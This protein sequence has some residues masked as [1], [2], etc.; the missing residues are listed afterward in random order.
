MDRYGRALKRPATENMQSWRTTG[1]RGRWKLHAVRREVGEL[2]LQ[3]V[4]N[5]PFEPRPKSGPVSLGEQPAWLKIDRLRGR[6]S[7]RHGLR[8][9]AGSSTP[10]LRE[11]Q[12]L[13]WLRSHGFEALEPLAAGA[14]LRAGLPTLQFLFT[15]RISNAATLL[16]HLEG[17]Q[18]RPER[19]KL[20]EDL[21][22]DLARLHSLGF[23]HH[24]LFLRNLLVRASAD[25]PR[26]VFIDTWRG[27]PA[28]QWRG[29]DYDL[30]CLLLEGADL[31]EERELRIFLDSYLRTQA[32]MKAAAR[33]RFL[34]RV[35]R[36]RLRLLRRLEQ[37]PGRR[38][39]RPLPS[40]TWDPRTLDLEVTRVS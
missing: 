35:H 25:R 8:T 33:A 11:F 40:V 24:D 12:N 13:L 29:P 27:G 9:L 36:Q 28:P 18:D 14:L 6:A 31:L 22:R 37:Q 39:G 4:E 3:L 20:I 7:L 38:R 26:L 34:S 2:A 21:G 32:P 19:A 16:E 1:P 30:A 5:Q 15:S 23:I 17:S 10:R